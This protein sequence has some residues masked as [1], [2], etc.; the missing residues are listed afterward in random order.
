MCTTLSQAVDVPELPF[1]QISRLATQA[2]RIGDIVLRFLDRCHGAEGSAS[3]C[4]AE[5][6][7]GHIANIN[8]LASNLDRLEK[9]ANYLGALG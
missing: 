8:R 4:E 9:L 2:D 5:P 7:S 1:D 6:P 3:D